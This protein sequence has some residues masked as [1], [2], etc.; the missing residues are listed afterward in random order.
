MAGEGCF[1]MYCQAAVRPVESLEASTSGKALS[2]PSCK[3]P[4]SAHE[5]PGET[6]PPSLKQTCKVPGFNSMIE[7]GRPG[8]ISARVF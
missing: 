2:G 4:S 3:F 1:N 7:H 8:L 5:C 6:A